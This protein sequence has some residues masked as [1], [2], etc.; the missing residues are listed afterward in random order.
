MRRPDLGGSPG[1]SPAWAIL[2]P[3]LLVFLWSTGFVGAKWALPYAEPFTL[4]ALRFAIAAVAF[5]GLALVAGAPWPRGRRQ[6]RDASLVGILLHGGYLTGVFW[7]IANGTPAWMAALIVGFNPLLTAVLAGPYLGERVTPRQWAGFA[8]GFAGVGLV[9]WQGIATG[10]GP[11]PGTLALILGLFAFSSGT[12]YQKRH[13]GGLDL[14][15]GQAVQLTGSFLL[16]GVLALVFETGEIDWTVDFILS[17][18][19]LSL[20]LSVGMFSLLFALIR[21]S[22]L[23]RVSS[24]FF[25]V[26]PLVALETHVLFGE[27]MAVRDVIGMALAALGVALVSARVR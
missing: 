20:V 15:S 18:A 16:V 13:G 26:P 14:R 19:W 6:I 25:L 5:L 11:L 12:L 17:L 1:N 3:V 7:S 27:A 4:S 9:V 21:R 8:L 2:A 10:A 22:A 23:T 24:L